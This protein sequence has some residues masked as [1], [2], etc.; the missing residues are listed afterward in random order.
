[1]ICAHLHFIHLF[2]WQVHKIIYICLAEHSANA[3]SVLATRS[4]VSE[5]MLGLDCLER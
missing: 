5:G 1:M 4:F 3:N 2:P